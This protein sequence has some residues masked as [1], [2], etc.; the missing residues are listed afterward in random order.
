[1]SRFIEQMSLSNSQ[2]RFEH[3]VEDFTKFTNGHFED[4]ISLIGIEVNWGILIYE[5]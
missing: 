3:M 2:S 5:L 4:D 1:M